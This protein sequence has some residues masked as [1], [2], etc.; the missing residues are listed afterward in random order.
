MSIATIRPGFAAAERAYIFELVGARERGGVLQREELELKRRD[1]LPLREE[2]ELVAERVV[3]A[4]EAQLGRPH[5]VLSAALAAQRQ[6]VHADQLLDLQRG[7]RSLSLSGGLALALAR[8]GAASATSACVAAAIAVLVFAVPLIVVRHQRDDFPVL[9]RLIATLALG[10]PLGL[11]L[12]G[13]GAAIL[14]RA[15]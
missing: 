8:A 3:L 1:V 10:R 15:L 13:R 12:D 14:A 5:G 7:S 4:F 9:Q 6:H 2:E 11:L